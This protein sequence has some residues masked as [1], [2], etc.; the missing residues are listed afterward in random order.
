VK[1]KKVS[2][3]SGG[4][5]VNARRSAALA[6]AIILFGSSLAAFLTLEPASTVLAGASVP[7]GSTTLRIPLVV[8]SSC[9]T[10]VQLLSAWRKRPGIMTTDSKVTGFSYRACWRNW[11]IAAPIAVPQGNGYF[12]FSRTPILH[13]LSASETV[14]FNRQVCANPSALKRWGEPGL[15]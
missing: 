10:S 1:D 9:P 6:L 14:A 11:V 7:A 5:A 8:R 15:C 3:Y 13:G 12:Y 2:Q 4:S